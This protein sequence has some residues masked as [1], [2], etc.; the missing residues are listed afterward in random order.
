MDA[1]ELRARR[2]AAGDAPG[3]ARRRVRIG[4]RESGALLTE[5]EL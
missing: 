5:M 1:P 2:E 3:V 4:G